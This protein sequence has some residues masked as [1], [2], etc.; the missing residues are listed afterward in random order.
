VVDLA[1][2]LVALAVVGV[3]AWLVFNRLT[4][5]KQGRQI[6]EEQEQEQGR[7]KNDLD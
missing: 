2:Q 1:N 3:A 4:D 5:E 6:E 7:D